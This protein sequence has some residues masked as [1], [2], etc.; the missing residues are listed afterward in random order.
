MPK[1]TKSFQDITDQLNRI[2]A[3]LAQ[4]RARWDSYEH[5][6]TIADNAATAYRDNIRKAVAK[7]NMMPSAG[8]VEGAD[9]DIQ[10]SQ[11]VYMGL[12]GG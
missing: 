1:R 5:R 6:R 8:R 7:R 9:R 11:R 12:N 10:F 2:N 4:S 3:L